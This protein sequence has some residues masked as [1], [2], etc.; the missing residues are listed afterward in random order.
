VLSCYLM[1]FTTDNGVQAH[2]HEFPIIT[3]MARDFLAIPRTMASVERL[4]SKS[5]HLCTDQRS[6]LKAATLTQA[7]CTKEWLREGLMKWN[8]HE[9][10]LSCWV[11]KHRFR[12]F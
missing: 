5:R 4:F 6:S 8:S 1:V 10:E 9:M 12:W 3:R 2:Q 11:P 7:M